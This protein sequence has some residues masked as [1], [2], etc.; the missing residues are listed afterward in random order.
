M[1]EKQTKL[2]KSSGSA[3]SLIENSTTYFAGGTQ[4]KYLYIISNNIEVY[5]EP[6]PRTKNGF[7]TAVKFETDEDK[8]IVYETL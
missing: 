4:Y 3:I 5:E 1:I 2:M 8:G 7:H 6:V